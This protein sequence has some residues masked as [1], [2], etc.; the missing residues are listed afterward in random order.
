M[1][2]YRFKASKSSVS[3][4]TIAC[5]GLNLPIQ[6]KAQYWYRN[7]SDTVTDTIDC[8][9]KNLLNKHKLSIGI[10]ICLILS[11]TITFVS[12][13]FAYTY[14]GFIRLKGTVA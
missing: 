2:K 13:K 4:D 7:M 12:K 6:S 9:G 11:D 3:T 10:V 5:V 8:V 1:L 14:D